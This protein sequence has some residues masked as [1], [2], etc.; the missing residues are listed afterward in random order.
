MALCK[1]RRCRYVYI[2]MVIIKKVIDE[3]KI[4]WDLYR[5]AAFMKKTGWTEEQYRNFTDPD[6]N[7]RASRVKDYYH[8]YTHIVTF[9]SSR[10][11]PWT[12]YLNWLEAYNAL[13]EWCKENCKDKWRTDIHRVIKDYSGEWTLNDIG[14]GDVL[15]F[16]FKSQEDAFMF[17]LKWG[18][19]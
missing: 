1:E 7:T 12:R 9:E 4:R 3:L 6:R 19:G 5:H 18:G 16:A 2:E 14:G 8:G 10:G 15:F 11:D 13:E 17:K